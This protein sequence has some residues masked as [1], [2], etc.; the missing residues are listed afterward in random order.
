V[1]HFLPSSGL[2]IKKLISVPHQTRGKM[3]YS[4]TVSETSSSLRHTLSRQPLREKVTC[5]QLDFCY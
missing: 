2:C 1:S 3:N 5:I 4:Y